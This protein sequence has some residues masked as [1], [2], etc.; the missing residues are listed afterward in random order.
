MIP[1]IWLTT[2]FLAGDSDALGT[3]AAA[4]A[5]EPVV[6][7]TD[8]FRLIIGPDGL[9]R[10]LTDKRGGREYASTAPPAPWP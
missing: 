3:A 4:V 9:L 2:I 10:S 1:R 5:R 7:E 8:S 6:L